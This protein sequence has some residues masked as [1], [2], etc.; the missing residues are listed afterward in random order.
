M[1]LENKQ[2]RM[3]RME[4]KKVEIYPEYSD[5]DIDKLQLQA[6]GRK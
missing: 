6:L 5:L 4:E 3:R 2:F 1:Y